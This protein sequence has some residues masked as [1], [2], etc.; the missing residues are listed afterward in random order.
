MAI[1]LTEAALPCKGATKGTSVKR[2]PAVRIGTGGHNSTLVQR[3]HQKLQ[4]TRSL[5]GPRKLEGQKV[6]VM[7]TRKGCLKNHGGILVQTQ[8][9]RR[10]LV[11]GDFPHHTPTLYKFLCPHQL[12]VLSPWK[13]K[14]VYVSSEHTFPRF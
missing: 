12:C 7:L 13:L 5:Q 4:G 11:Y 10:A 8:K 6:L 3:T 1:L 2:L 9:S 14:E